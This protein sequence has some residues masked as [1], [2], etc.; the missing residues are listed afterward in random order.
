MD[1]DDCGRYPSC[2]LGF[3]DRPGPHLAVVGLGST[4]HRTDLTVPS[5]RVQIGEIFLG[6]KWLA[7]FLFSNH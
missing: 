5:L 7:M 4:F 2:S 3:K 1:E 6:Y